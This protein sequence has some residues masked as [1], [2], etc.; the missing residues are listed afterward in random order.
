[1]RNRNAVL[2]LCGAKTTDDVMKIIR[3]HR[4]RNAVALRRTSAFFDGLTGSVSA[5]VVY[6]AL[7]KRD[8]DARGGSDA[9]NEHGE[10]SSRTT[11]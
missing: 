11:R 1:M 8:L 3:R 6:D 9:V 10:M 2:W 4:S 5:R 7:R